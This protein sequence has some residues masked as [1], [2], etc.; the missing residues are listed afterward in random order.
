VTRQK[1]SRIIVDSGATSHFV[2]EDMNLPKTGPSYKPIYL[3]NDTT[4]KAS[5][6]TMLP[7]NQLTDKAREAEILPVLKRPL[8]SVNTMSKEGYT[9]IFHPGEEGV[10]I[11]K[12]GT[13]QILTTDKPVLT[14]TNSNG[15]WTIATKEIDLKENINHAYSIPS[16]EGKIRFLQAA[17]GFPTK[18]TWLKAIKAGNYITWPGITTKT[19]NR[20]FPK[21]D[22]TTK[23]HMKKQCQNVRSTRVQEE[24]PD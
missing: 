20:H 19:V 8:M 21:S 12:P 22:E 3:P 16:M 9:T 17:A 2:T 11:H 23:G 15:L 7:F 6:K 14:G 5:A 1:E 10:T 13:L 18:E 4:L 24:I